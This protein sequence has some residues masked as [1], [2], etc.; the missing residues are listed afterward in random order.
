MPQALFFSELEEPAPAK[1]TNPK[2]MSWFNRY[3][4]FIIETRWNSEKK[5]YDTLYHP[6]DYP[7]ISKMPNE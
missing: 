4:G 2:P 7:D 3:G 1:I 6:Y 5:Q